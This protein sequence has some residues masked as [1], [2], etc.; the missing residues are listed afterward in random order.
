[1]H[2]FRIESKFKREF[3][4]QMRSF[5]VVFLGFT[6]AFTW[7]QT[8]FDIS[9][10]LMEAIT[11]IKN[12]STLSILSSIFITLVSILLIYRTSNLLKEDYY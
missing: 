10:S 12:S 7:R 5:I 2:L 1:M 6:I 9:T 4:R 8:I 11:H 3:R